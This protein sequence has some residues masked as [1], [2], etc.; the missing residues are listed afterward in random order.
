M[1]TSNWY[2]FFLFQSGARGIHTAAMKGHIPVIKNLLK[3]GENVDAV[4]KVNVEIKN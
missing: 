4:T 1:L 3:K 2:H